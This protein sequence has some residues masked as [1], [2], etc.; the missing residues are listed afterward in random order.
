MSEGGLQATIGG[1]C[2]NLPTDR[3]TPAKGVA[4]LTS[5]WTLAPCAA[6]VGELG[7][8]GPTDQGGPT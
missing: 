1:Q 6:L 5:K 8:G 2:S 4:V 3:Q 7:R